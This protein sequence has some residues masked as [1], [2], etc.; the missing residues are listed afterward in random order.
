MAHELIPEEVRELLGAYALDALDA[1]ERSQ[2]EAHVLTDADARAE[3]H[4]LQLG[5]SW[6]AQSSERPPEEAWD[7]IASRLDV[8]D[9]TAVETVS[10]NMVELSTR[11]SITRTTARVS[12]IAAAVLAVVV[13]VG[14]VRSAVVDDTNVS[15]T[16]LAAAA[17]AARTTP[18]ATKLPLRDDDGRVA[19]TAVVL[20]GGTGIL[21]A[22]LPT[23]SDRHTYELWALSDDGSVPL[24]TFGPGA[25]ARVFHADGP[26]SGMAVTDE[27]VG[28][29]AKPTGPVVARGDLADA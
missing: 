14:G 10:S 19:A 13:L 24:G 25:R 3:L 5:A 28:G 6:L 18:G 17:R 26:M 4:A 7:R 22:D 11:R 15:D 27:P 29:S 2:V 21:T 20:P 16:A 8:E 12:A 9:L 23:L 1:D